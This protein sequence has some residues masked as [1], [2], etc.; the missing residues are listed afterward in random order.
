MFRL[1]RAICHGSNLNNCN[2]LVC[3]M[4]HNLN[5]YLTSID[6]K[7]ASPCRS[8]YSLNSLGVD[9]YVDKREK[10]KQYF[11]NDAD[12]FRGKMI[13]F[14]E[15]DQ[16]SMIFTEDLKNMIHLA[17][18]KDGDIELLERMLRK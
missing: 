10:V 5:N 7:K 8:L 14:V 3:T 1:S 16:T 18:S 13:D 9:G 12:K 15:N 17:D 2:F 4:R 11:S 6:I